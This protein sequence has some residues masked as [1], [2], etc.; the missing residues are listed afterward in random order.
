MKDTNNFYDYNKQSKTIYDNLKRNY[1]QYIFSQDGNA[2]NW[3]IKGDHES[4]TT[5]TENVL[6]DKSTDKDFE[7]HIGEIRDP[8]KGNIQNEN[9]TIAINWSFF[10]FMIIIMISILLLIIIPLSA[11]K[12]GASK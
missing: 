11:K 12:E 5:Y 8:S 4:T 2:G 9:S 1:D 7:D 10:L 3:H 6:T